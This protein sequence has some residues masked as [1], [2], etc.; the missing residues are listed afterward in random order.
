MGLAQCG[1]ACYLHGN[2][3]PIAATSI[4]QCRGCTVRPRELL[5]ARRLDGA[6]CTVSLVTPSTVD[7]LLSCCCESDGLLGCFCRA[8]LLGVAAWRQNP[9]LLRYVECGRAIRQGVVVGLLTTATIAKTFSHNDGRSAH[10][11]FSPQDET[12]ACCGQALCPLC[13]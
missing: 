9:V 2:V 1:K 7:G 11:A 12:A 8:S 10:C 3:P 5:P 13:A 6:E 4:Q